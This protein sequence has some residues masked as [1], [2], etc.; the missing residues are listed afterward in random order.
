ML[1]FVQETE[2]TQKMSL[3]FP[4]SPQRGLEV[5]QFCRGICCKEKVIQLIQVI[6]SGSKRELGAV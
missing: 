3:L 4:R 5:K 1:V 6:Q 2:A